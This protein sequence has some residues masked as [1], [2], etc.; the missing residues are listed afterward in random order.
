MANVDLALIED[1]YPIIE[2][3]RRLE[4]NSQS[5]RNEGA[6][7]SSDILVSRKVKRNA[8]VS[9]RPVDSRGNEVDKQSRNENGELG[10][11]LTHRMVIRKEK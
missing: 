2:M 9:S 10:G 3:S 7:V 4:M 1:T 8:C 11:V 5:V 6:Q